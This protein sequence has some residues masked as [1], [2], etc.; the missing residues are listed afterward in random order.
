M[1]NDLLHELPQFSRLLALEYRLSD[2]PPLAIK[3]PV[4]AAIIDAVMGYNY[5]VNE[6]GFKPSN[7]LVLG[8]SAGGTLTTQFTKYTVVSGVSSL[9]PPGGILLL[10]PS[11]DWGETHTHSEST[12]LRHRPTDW[13]LAFNQGYCSRAMLG[14]LPWSEAQTN[15]WFSPASLALHE[16]KGTFNGFP[17]TMF[18][19][20]GAEMTLDGMRTSYERMRQDVGDEN[21]TWVEIEDATHVILALPW[22]ETE[23]EEAYRAV[24]RWTDTIF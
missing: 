20:G 8:D 5:L 12:M 13:I 10:S 15:W 3:N 4:P 7:I 2:G 6:L 18:L 11:M 24:R 9:P 14:H 16:K 1:Y 23:K 19:V 17:A 22:H 21:V